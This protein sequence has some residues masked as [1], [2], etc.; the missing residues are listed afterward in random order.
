MVHCITQQHTES[1]AQ[2]ERSNENRIEHAAFLGLLTV[3]LP[4]QGSALAPRELAIAR[5]STDARLLSLA[6]GSARVTALW[7][8]GTLRSY[9]AS[10]AVVR[11]SDAAL[12]DVQT[13]TP[14]L[15]MRLKGFCIQHVQQVSNVGPQEEH[16]A[17]LLSITCAR[18]VICS[19]CRSFL[20]RSNGRPVGP[21]ERFAAYRV[22]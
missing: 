7:S 15:D 3:M 9:A 6:A 14:R 12:D 1:P 18:S 8:D 10:D 13:A 11:D 5:P 2:H 20:P 4:I 22:S 17:C 16:I 21:D 19:Q